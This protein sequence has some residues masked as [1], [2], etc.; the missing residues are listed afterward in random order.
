MSTEPIANMSATVRILVRRAAAGATILAVCAG[1]AAAPAPI[2]EAPRRE[3][4][5]QRILPSAVQI[6]LENPE[7]RRVRTGSGVAI[8]ARGSECFVVTSG[9]TVADSVGKREIALFFGRQ[10]GAGTRASAIVLA[11]RE[12][13]DVDIALLRAETDQC[14]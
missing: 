12:T 3:N 8:A 2:R 1:C 4:V 13:E 5:L 14:V 11:H 7:G 9:H 10:R 6:I